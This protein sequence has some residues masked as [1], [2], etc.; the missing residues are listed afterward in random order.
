[1]AIQGKQLAPNTVTATETS[2]AAPVEIT[3]STNAEGAASTLARSN[4]QHA[5]GNRGGG[6]LHSDVDQSTAGFMS[7]ADKIKLDSLQDA[8][9]ID[10][11]E[12]VQVRAQGNLTL[13]GEQ[14]IDG[15]LTS[16]D[17]VLVDQQTTTT[18]DGIYVTAAGA[19]TRSGD[20]PTGAE[21]RGWTLVV[22]QGTV[23]GGKLMQ[24]TN[25]QGSDVVGTDD[26]TF[27]QVGASAKTPAQERVTTETINN[28]D[29][30]LADTLNNT[31]VSDASV[32]L[33]LNGVALIQGAGEDYTISGATITW[34][35]SSGTAPNLS[36]NDDLVAYYMF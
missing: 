16:T 29:Q 6:T 21:A 3:D 11:K 26:L 31:P 27:A 18:E 30:A 8:A 22:E 2:T 32:L 35:A 14:T 33:L 23:D 12:S 20:A 13:S 4:H 34:L 1:M 36:T 28:V 19:W 24:C 17:R 10:A 15:I 25:V 7:A 5:H 9:G